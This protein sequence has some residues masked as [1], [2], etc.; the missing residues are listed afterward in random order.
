MV[1]LLKLK[2]DPEAPVVGREGLCAGYLLQAEQSKEVEGGRE[3]GAGTQVQTVEPTA[4]LES[5]APFQVGVPGKK[6][7][8]IV[9]K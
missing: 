4:R 3:G 7:E 5:T 8:N 2:I 9:D 1:R 6:K